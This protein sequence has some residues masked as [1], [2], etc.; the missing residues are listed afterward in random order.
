MPAWIDWQRDMMTWRESVE[1]RLGTHEQVLHLVPEILERLG[2]ATLSPEHQRTV[3]AGVN[4][5]HEL[6][7][8][9][10]AAIY[11]DLREAF[12]VGTYKDIL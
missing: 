8:R 7:K 10:H 4:H 1:R 6:T 2:P 5:L 9:P 12:R 3:Q 11:N